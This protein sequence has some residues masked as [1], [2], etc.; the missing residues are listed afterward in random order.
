[1]RVYLPVTVAR[2]AQLLADSELRAAS[3]TAFALTPALREAYSSG[4]VDELEHAAFTQAARAALRLL[5]IEGAE[6]EGAGLEGA[7]APGEPDAR[8]R[9]AAGTSALLRRGVLSADVDGATLRPDLDDAVVRLSGPVRLDQVAAVHL[10]LAAA[11][12]AVS[13]AIEAVDAADMGDLDAELIV[14]EATDHELAWY[15][16]QELGFLLELF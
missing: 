1:M 9:S 3:G 11:E 15:A 7:G 12:G 6:L 2:L 5:A 14:G 10:D 16:P 4:G 8:P 13:A